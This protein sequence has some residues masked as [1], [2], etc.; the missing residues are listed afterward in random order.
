MLTH[1]ELEYRRQKVCDFIYTPVVTS[2]SAY[3]AGNAVGGLLTIDKNATGDFPI[4]EP[5]LS[6]ILRNL[7]VIDLANQKPNL[8]LYL[9]SKA[10]ATTPTDKSAWSPVDADLLALLAHI[11]IA[12]G[13]F[14]SINSRA[15]A[16]SSN[17]RGLNRVL[18]PDWA[19]GKTALYGVL[20]TSSTPTFTSTSSLQLRF[21]FTPGL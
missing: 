20:T 12:T 6:A 8:D 17:Q 1:T 5:G 16:D 7:V 13:D 4:Q 18:K 9:F 3:A 19:A 10:P 15:Y 2:G 11:P 14:T 21:H